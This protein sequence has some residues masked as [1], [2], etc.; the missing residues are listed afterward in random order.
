MSSGRAMMEVFRDSGFP[1]QSSWTPHDVPIQLVQVIPAIIL[2]I[3]SDKYPK[4]HADASSDQPC[5]R[6]PRP[7]SESNLQHGRGR[8]TPPRA[9]AATRPPSARSMDRSRLWPP[10]GSRFAWRAPWIARCAT[11]WPNARKARRCMWRIASIPCMQ[12]LANDGLANQ[13]HPSYTRM[14]PAHY[15]VDLA[16]VGCPDPDPTYTRFFT[17]HE[18][19]TPCRPR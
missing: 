9:H 12:A 16:L 3:P 14:V 8:R 11:S 17:P 10:K 6:S 1:I 18:G 13:F 5:G 2:L 7:V 15:V 19:R 4:I